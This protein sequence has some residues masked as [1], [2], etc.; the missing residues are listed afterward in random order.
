MFGLVLW[1]INLCRLFNAKSIFIHRNRSISNNSVYHKN[2]QF[3]IIVHSLVLFDLQVGPYQVP[4]LRVR[5]K[6][7]TMAINEYS[8]SPKLKCYWNLTSRLFSVISR[9]LV[10]GVLPLYR[11]AI[12]VYC[13]PKYKS[14]INIFALNEKGPIKQVSNFLAH[15]LDIGK[16]QADAY[17]SIPAHQS[18][19]RVKLRVTGFYVVL[20][21]LIAEM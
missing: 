13:S 7:G 17:R 15:Q 2:S 20:F 14:E 5:M 4:P 16:N 12:G 10:G 11:D 6:L 19:G 9:T 18:I 3:Q 8:A 21:Y 1:Y